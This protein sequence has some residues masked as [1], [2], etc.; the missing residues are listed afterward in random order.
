M[1][2]DVRFAPVYIEKQFK[3]SAAGSIMTSFTD[4]VNLT[5]RYIFRETCLIFKSQALDTIR[6]IG[7]LYRN[8]TG[9]TPSSKAWNT[10]RDYCPR[11]V[12][13]EQVEESQ[14]Q[15]VDYSLQI[16]QKIS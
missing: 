16:T 7:E 2:K 8:A 6:L 11:I 10:L 13:S 14:S 4:K 3:S 1:P 9:S 15:S 12:Q 5:R